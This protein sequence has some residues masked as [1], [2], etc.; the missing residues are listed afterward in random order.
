MST[1]FLG[2]LLIDRDSDSVITVILVQAYSN[3][4]K[5]DYQSIIMGA[6]GTY[7]GSLFIRLIINRPPLTTT[8]L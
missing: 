5:I 1:E 8:V 3:L 2:T 7:P 4:C 6:C